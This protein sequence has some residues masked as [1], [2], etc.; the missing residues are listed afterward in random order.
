MHYVRCTRELFVIN[1]GISMQEYLCKLHISYLYVRDL[2]E[3]FRVDYLRQSF[4]MFSCSMKRTET[5]SCKT[6]L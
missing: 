1:A 5:Y 3:Y 6:D 4:C 2:E